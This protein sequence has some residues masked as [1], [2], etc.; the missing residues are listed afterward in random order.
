MVR[1]REDIDV[2]KGCGIIA[3]M[4]FH[5]GVLRS[6]YLGVDMFFV[7]NGFFII[8]SIIKNI[9]EGNFS[10]V[11]F[12]EKRFVRLY[13]LVLIICASAI[14][15]GCI[16]MLPFELERTARSAIACSVMSENLRCAYTYGDYWE[17]WND[18]SPLFHLWYVGIL[19]EFYL[20]FP[21]V[22]LIV[23]KYR[24]GKYSSSMMELACGVLFLISIVCYFLP[25]DKSL[26]FYLLPFR[27][28]EILAG[29]LIAI[30]L[31]K[32]DSERFANN[33]ILFK[34]SR[35]ILI[36]IIYSSILFVYQDG[37][38]HQ[39][40]PIAP[41]NIGLKTEGLH[42]SPVIMQLMTVLASS[43]VLIYYTGTEG[44]MFYKLSSYIGK[45]SYSLF[46]WHQF[47]LAFYRNMVSDEITWTSVCVYFSVSFALSYLTYCLVEQKVRPRRSA[48]RFCVI[49][50]LLMFIPSSYIYLN[51]GV[52]RDIPE[53]NLKKG[54]G[55]P[56]ITVAY[57][58]IPVSFERKPFE[59][60]GNKNVL[61]VGNSFARD[62]CNILRESNY[63]K[64]LNFSYCHDGYPSEITSEAD[65]IF[66]FF[67]KETITD[68][69]QRQLKES[70]QVYGIG[71]KTFGKSNNQF[72]SHRW[73][74]SYFES[75][76][77]LPEEYRRANVLAKEHWGEH[78]IDLIKPALTDSNHIR[79]FTP[80][81]KYISQDCK[82][83][84]Q[85]GAKWYASVLNLDKIF[86]Q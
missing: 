6:G 71:T 32:F 52:I 64:A 86:R 5:L 66:T 18:Y 57:V 68:D 15:L 10:Y 38:G 21:L 77:Q 33:R 14:V 73:S 67:P 25:F 3:I 26:K 61:V 1:Y 8:P 30:A 81:H 80:D 74:E 34:L 24:K 49:S 47:V 42:F 37:I 29:G 22:L 7:I 45:R 23:K 41:Y 72:Y 11:S 76:T 60:N 85:A 40:R 65:Y 19:F 39:V 2:M 79:V 4:L 69:I 63:G 56:N 20:L 59:D 83:L 51:G 27:L 44:G 62:F 78:Y 12:L 46:L 53:L 16:F 58:G 13:P 36:L 55:R 28:F 17:I 9:S 84:T 75:K 82:H 31:G 43:F 35:V 54:E 70:C 48:V 50:S